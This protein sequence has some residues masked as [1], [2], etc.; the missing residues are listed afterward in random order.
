MLQRLV[1]SVVFGFGA[2]AGRDLDDER[3][4]LKEKIGKR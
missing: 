2:S 3:A 4:V 1:E